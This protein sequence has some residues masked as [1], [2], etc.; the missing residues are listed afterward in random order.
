MPHR[1]EGSDWWKTRITLDDGRTGIFACGTTNPEIAQDVERM[2]QTFQHD[3]R[4]EPLRLALDK[5]AKLGQVYDAF[6]ANALEEFLSALSAPDLSPLV[7]EWPAKSA[8]YKTQV[9]C[10]IPEGEIF[11]ASEFTAVRI[12]ALLDGLTVSGSTKNR[13]HAAVSAFGKWLK[14]KGV[15]PSNIVRDVDRATPNKV[16]PV[17]LDRV[18]AK[19]LI[20]ALPM[21]FRAIEALMAATGVE[22]QVVERLTRRDIDLKKR[23]VHARGGKNAWRNRV[24]RGTELW[25]WRIFADYA[26]NFTDAAQLFPGIREDTAL[27]VHKAASKTLSLPTTTLHGWRRTY[28]V[29]ALRDGYSLQVVAHQLGHKDTTLVQKIYGQFV[30]EEADYRRHPKRPPSNPRRRPVRRGAVRSA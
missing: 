20:S 23:T 12:A 21:P 2:V 22:W 30:V 1:P 8:K 13:Y 18:Q 9:R 26:K 24:V 15:I 5:K 6:K 11:R 7:A 28:A 4:W 16:V 29:Q 10:L 17:W 3:R 25:A 14:R 19:A 27:R